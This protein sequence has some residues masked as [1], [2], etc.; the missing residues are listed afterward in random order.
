MMDNPTPVDNV[1]P[2]FPE[3]TPSLQPKERPISNSDQRIVIIAGEESGDRYGSEL[4]QQLMHWNSSLKMSGIGGKHMQ[5][6]GV[7]LVSDLARFGVTGI[8]EVLRHLWII[9]KAF[10]DIK[11]HL[12][13]TKPQI[14]ILI[15]YPG[16][17]LR[18]AKFAK[19]TLGL[20]IIYY[21]SPQIWAWK[22]NRLETIRRHVD[23]MA[24]I[25]PFEKNIYQKAGVPVSFVGH[26]LIENIPWQRYDQARAE[27]TRKELNLSSAH[28]LVAL[29]PGSRTHEIK[30]HLP[31]M[32][33]A[34]KYLSQRHPHIHF[35][36]PV[37]QNL[38]LNTFAHYLKQKD[39]LD[40]SITCVHGDTL[41]LVN[42][43][44]CV[45]VASGT[46]SLECALVGK[47]MC[48]V[49]KATYLTYLIATKV[50]N[51]KYLGLCNLLSQRMIVPELLQYDF[52]VKELSRV[53]DLLLEN[54]AV[55]DRM[56]SH[57]KAI[58]TSLSPT[59]ADSSLLEL[60]KNAL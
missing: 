24:V 8:S 45:A 40:L 27:T 26:P 9:K 3:K 56:V 47:P 33:Q 42:A 50:I 54:Q 59:Q 53:L 32:L 57:L 44:D 48:I 18:L 20:H 11:K 60:I 38:S 37:A 21:I 2:S 34:A 55:A 23:H 12:R 17:N 22:A 25:L 16:F 5:K 52:N 13:E 31:I 36:I 35:I 29:L 58:K 46:A 51:V 6:A 4:A 49:Y 41:A 39:V 14:L 28:P 7:E 1:A 43:C 10:K 19:T 30:Q 15:D